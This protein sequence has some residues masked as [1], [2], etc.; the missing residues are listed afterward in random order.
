ME[1]FNQGDT[2]CLIL[3]YQLNGQPLEENAYDEIEFQINPQDN[4]NSIKKLLSKGEIEW[5]TVDYEEDDVQKQFTG[6]VTYLSQ[7]ETF[8]LRRG[9]SECQ[10]RILV[11]D[12][13]G[14][15]DITDLSLG[16]VLSKKVLI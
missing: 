6:Y 5:E 2:A 1:L 10:I 11:G 15:S 8:T 12:E 4:A 3:N 9:T 13:V 16:R 14:S 7:E